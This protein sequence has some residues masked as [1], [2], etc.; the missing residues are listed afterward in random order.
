[1]SKYYVVFAG[2]TPGIYQS[3]KKCQSEVVGVK[4]ASF[5]SFKDAGTAARAFATGNLAKWRRREASIMESVWKKCVESHC[6]AV[7][8]ACS[9]SPGP[10]EYRGVMLPDRSTVFSHGPFDGGS[11]N[12]GE[13][14]AIYEGLKWIADRTL[15]LCVYSD[16]KVAMGW[17]SGQGK[18]RTTIAN[19]GSVLSA[20][21]AEAEKW[22][23]ENQ[24]YRS[25]IKKWDTSKW[26]EIPADF[27]RK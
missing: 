20:K 15:D 22:L 8:A 1:M 6:L 16:S 27:G 17:V 9:G 12:I 3:W 24:K 13:F 11:N 7:D 23:Q 5:A 25:R 10:V 4:G 21:I 14:L 19:V 26:G 18:C 2:R